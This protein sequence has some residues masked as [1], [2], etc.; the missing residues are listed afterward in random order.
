[1]QN[2]NHYEVL[3]VGAAAPADEIKRAFR[4]QIAR[5]HPDKVQ[6]LGKEFQDMAAGRAAELTEAYRV[7]SNERDRAEYD[8]GLVLGEGAAP[9]PRERPPSPG[10]PPARDAEPPRRPSAYTKD[11]ASRDRFVRQATLDRIRKTFAL[12][13]ADYNET[14]IRGFDMALLPRPKLFG[15]AAGPCI[16]GRFIEPVNGAAVADAWAMAVK[17]TS[18][19]DEVCVL[20]LGSLVAP[21]R[22]LAE[23]I[24]EQ[25][26]RNRSVNIS[27]I[28]VDVRTWDAH[29]PVGAPPVCRD[30]LTRLRTG[31]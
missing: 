31:N 4:H 13:G 29:M 27:I 16:L 3:E 14:Q 11:R 12:V 26:R 17:G 9:L 15:A 18:A 21:A 22:E 5:Y 23:A 25:R 6:H 10:R 19:K 28:P 30:L 7:L 2:K 24:A 8:R 1:V 20:L